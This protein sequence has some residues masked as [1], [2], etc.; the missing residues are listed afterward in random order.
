MVTSILL[1][2]IGIALV[3]LAASDF[4]FTA[5]V[6][7]GEGVITARLGRGI[8]NFMQ[9]LAGHDGRNQLLNYIGL[10]TIFSIITVWILLLWTGFTF[11]FAADTNSILVGQDKTPADIFEKVYHVGYTLSTLGMGDFVPGNDFWRILT[12]FIS[13]VGMVLVTMSISYLVP[14]LSN[15]IHKRSLS[16]Q[17]SSLGATPEEIVINS[18]NGKDFSSATGALSDLSA[19]IF[20]YTQNH[21]A[22]PILHYMHSNTPSENIALK[23]TALDEA[24]TIFM[25]H[26][27]EAQRPDELQ[28]QSVRRAITAYLTTITYLEPASEPPPLPRFQII[29]DHT[30]VKLDRTSPLDARELYH[31]L[32][33]RR[34]LLLADLRDGGWQW[35]DIGGEK[36][37][38]DL[39]V[40]FANKLLT[41]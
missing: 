3:L 10:V 31:G 20:L 39:D 30:G 19:E 41:S 37:E 12:S 38:T 24:L 29:E 27:P 15:A 7:T 4:A 11:I 13:F 5:F 6:L 9:W 14:V 35:D 28:L 32:E 22:Y 36:Y 40:P 8:Y 18:Y 21:L 16:L 25:F 26:V 23:L 33:K 34:K 17:I 2:M 1:V